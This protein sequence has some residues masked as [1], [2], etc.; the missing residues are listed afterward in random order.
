[1]L[2]WFGARVGAHVHLYPST[3][4][5]FP[6]LVQIGDWS[7]LGEN[8]L[9]YN[10]GLVVIGQKVTISH[11]THLCSGTHDYRLTDL[12]LLKMPIEVEDQAWLCAESFIGPGVSVGQGAIVGARAVV[13]KHVEPWTV[14]AGN[15]AKLIC[16]R[17]LHERP[18]SRP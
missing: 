18:A 2:R 5:L 15:P 6:W 10:P 1:M 7:A 12:P 14:V 4:I 16:V 9:V 11:G 8:V 3:E 17:T 13:T